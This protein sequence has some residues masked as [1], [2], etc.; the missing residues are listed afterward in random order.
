MEIKYGITQWSL[1]GK[2]PYAIKYAAE[3][4]LD[5]LQIELGYYDD[6]GYYMAQKKV[7]EDYMR[8]A[9][10]YGIEFPSIVLNDLGNHGFADPENQ[11]DCKIALESL[12]IAL[13]VAQ[14]MGIDIIMIP[15]FWKNEIVDEKTL[16]HSAKILRT[17]C[18][19]AGERGIC[20]DSE[21]TLNAERQIQLME[22]VDMPNFKTLYDSQNYYFFKG[23]DQKMMIE[24][25]YPYMGTQVH[26]KDC[27][28]HDY[29]PDGGALSGALLGQGD[30]NFM[31]TVEYLKK[32]N[33]SGWIISENYYYALP[34]RNL[35][36]DQFELL[37]E[38]MRHLREV[39][40]K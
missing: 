15:Q 22:A 16:E 8:D 38:D 39:L 3:A 28:G 20:V 35:K 17:F 18:Q 2:G 9:E 23:Y 19:K 24:K 5:G 27:Y 6:G 29:D 12:D 7:R 31:A 14:S 34:M 30:S 4:D 32:M 21:T 37:Q 11:K 36:E 10:K 26:V 40:E 1:P 13:D 25:L 33:Y